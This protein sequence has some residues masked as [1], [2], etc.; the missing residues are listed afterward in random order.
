[1]AATLGE[2]TVENPFAGV[3][4]GLQTPKG[5]DF[6]A[7][8]NATSV[9][10]AEFAALAAELGLEPALKVVEVDVGVPGPDGR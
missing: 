9:F 8:E 3:V 1:V 2:P 4:D 6:G 5:L 10:I 7:G